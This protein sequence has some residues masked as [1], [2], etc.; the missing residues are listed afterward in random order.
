MRRCP[1]WLALAALSCPAVA[2][3]GVTITI[4]DVGQGDAT[5]VESTSGQTLLFDGG[6]NGTGASVILPFLADEGIAALDFIVTS[7]Y[8]EDHIGGVDEVY[9]HTGASGGVWDRGWSYTTATYT[10]YANAVAADRHTLADGQVFDLGDGVTATCVCLNGNG[11]VNAPY[12]DSDLENEYCVGLLIECGDFDFFQAGDLIG[13]ND[14][15][16]VD[17]ETGLGQELLALG[18]ADLEIYR[19]SHHG[20]YTSSNAAFLNAITPEVALISVGADNTYGHP[21]LEPLQRLQT[22]DVFVYMTSEG[23]GATLPPADLAVV[24]GHIVVATTGTQTYTVDGDV[25]EMDEQGVSPVAI[26]PATFALLGNHPNPF[27]P[28]TIL[29]F[30]SERGGAGRLEIFDV[31]GRRT[32]DERFVAPAG[33]YQL[34]WRGVDHRGDAVPAGVYLYRLTMP[35]GQGTG[36]MTLAK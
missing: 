12:N 35:D 5:L 18:K 36:R 10:A 4:L 24:G 8:H 22:R 7:H 25:W 11:E 15:G 19:V 9:S 3:A 1:L 33:P 26:V 27:N 13:T 30:R 16:H 14:G 17:I 28:A 23:N 34:T 6:P 21:H 20:S 2:I 29:S 32:W 31:A